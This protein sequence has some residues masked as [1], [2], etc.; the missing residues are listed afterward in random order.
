MMT[1][2]TELAGSLEKHV[3]LNDQMIEKINEMI[4]VCS[5]K[6]ERVKRQRKISRMMLTAIKH[7]DEDRLKV[8]VGEWR[9]STK[10]LSKY[11]L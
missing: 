11:K 3:A 10:R 7:E 8:L 9:E 4:T 1:K 6:M 2:H 5:K